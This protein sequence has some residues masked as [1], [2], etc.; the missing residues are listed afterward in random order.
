[1]ETKLRKTKKAIKKGDVLSIANP[2]VHEKHNHDVKMGTGA[3]TLCDCTGFS[4]SDTGVC[5]TI[6]KNGGTC[7]HWESDHN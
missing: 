1:M 4:N 2:L 3:C 7:S 6:I 5:H